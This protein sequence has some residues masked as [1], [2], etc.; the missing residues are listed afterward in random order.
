MSMTTRKSFLHPHTLYEDLPTVLWELGMEGYGIYNRMLELMSKSNDLRLPIKDMPRW[1]ADMGVSFL[2]LT[3]L[4]H[5]AIDEA[6]FSTT[7][8]DQYLYSPWLTL[9][10]DTGEMVVEPYVEEGSEAGEEG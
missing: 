4:I 7:N 5:R 2:T 6:V 9:Q 1:A 10:K 8:D 3:K